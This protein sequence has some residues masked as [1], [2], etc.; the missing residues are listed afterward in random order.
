[1]ELKLGKDE[2]IIKSWDYAI[3]SKMLQA[4]G[5]KIQSN[6]TV[7]NKRIVASQYNDVYLKRDEIPLAAVKNISGEYRTAR[8]FWP[9]VKLIIGIP[10]CLLIVG[11]KIVK[12]AIAQLRAADFD[13]IITTSG[14]EGSSLGLGAFSF[15]P[16]KGGLFAKLKGLFKTKVR[17]SKE[18]SKEILD[19]LGAIVVDAQ[20]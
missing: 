20:A 9:I 10:L 3:S 16:A 19:E 15:A 8:K 1:M 11:I 5:K 7:T 17:V 14:V 18:A 4:K 12:G 2:Q 13:L 6:L